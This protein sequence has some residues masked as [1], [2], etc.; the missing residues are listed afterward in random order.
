MT[1]TTG[2][3]FDDRLRL[4]LE[5]TKEW[6]SAYGGYIAAAVIADSTQGFSLFVHNVDLLHP[7]MCMFELYGDKDLDQ[8]ER[9]ISLLFMAEIARDISKP[10]PSSVE[11]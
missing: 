1:G 9:V 8:Q 5:A 11:K 6:S 3:G 4:D 10:S 2:C 7:W